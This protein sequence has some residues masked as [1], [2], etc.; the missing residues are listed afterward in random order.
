[1]RTYQLSFDT[2][3]TLGIAG[4]EVEYDVKVT[5]RYSPALP[6]HTPRGEMAPVDPPEP[7]EFDVQT[8]TTTIKGK[9][10]D[11]LPLLKDVQMTALAAEGILEAER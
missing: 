5:G 1:M 6:A 3:L 8:A 10:V 2:V 11:I 9:L 7:A 4:C